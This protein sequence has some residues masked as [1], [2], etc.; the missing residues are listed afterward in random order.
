M[1]PKFTLYTFRE[2]QAATFPPWDWSEEFSP[3]TFIT[4]RPPGALK[5]LSNCLYVAT[6]TTA[7]RLQEVTREESQGLMG[8]WI[9]ATSF[10]VAQRGSL[11]VEDLDS[12]APKYEGVCI[13]ADV[14][15]PGETQRLPIASYNGIPTT[16][17]GAA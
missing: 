6:L 2:F 3:C 13:D 1:K 7:R 14:F 15:A 10:L 5:R 11:T 12:V 16:G 8:P 9:T 17:Q 4:S